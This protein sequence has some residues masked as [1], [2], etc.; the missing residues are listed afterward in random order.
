MVY[1]V[2]AP[3]IEGG[4]VVLE[5]G[6]IVEVGR[7]VPAGVPEQDL[8]EVALL[9][10]LVNAH[11]HLEFSSRKQ[12]LG[13]PGMEL[14]QWV[15]LVIGQRQTAAR[16][17][18]AITAGLAE[19]VQA[20]VTTVADIC[21]VVSPAY[22]ASHDSPRL[23]LL[24]EAIGYSQARAA[25]AKSGVEQNLAELT[26]L[27]TDAGATRAS[28]GVSPHAPYTASPALVR[29][30]VSV[31]VERGAP[32]ALH[33]AESEAE[34]QLIGAGNGPFQEL[35]EERGMWDPWA[36][37]RGATPMDYLRI[38][39]KAPRALV[40]HGNYLDDASLAMIGRHSG[41]MALVYCP[42]T[43]AYFEHPPYP[44]AKALSMGVRVCLGTDGLGSNPDL[45]LLSEMRHVARN[46]R[47]VSPEAVLRMGTLSGAEALGLER[48][49][50]CMRTG[51]P[52]DLMSIPLPAKASGGPSGML[53]A[54]LADEQ[55]AAGVW[56]DGQDLLAAAE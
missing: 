28:L 5:N 48:V 37:P 18:K 24:Q 6:R 32:V 46:H 42:R 26:S 10:G 45:S 21:R 17:G 8:G 50:G 41:A 51:M 36:I 30:L 2:A 49:A 34:L 43:H 3:P 40:V 29:E 23:V 1:P 38:L 52:A 20:G 56:V 4:V 15:R 19:S 44:L 35:L 9:P 31:A 13:K 12:P 55:P 27:A 54:I 14:H 39:T 11:C 53:E 7:R 22:F 47:G 16:I 33:L 25:S